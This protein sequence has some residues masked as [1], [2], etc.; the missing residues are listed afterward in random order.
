MSLALEP[1]ER[2]GKL[3]LWES[4]SALLRFI[5]SRTEHTWQDQRVITSEGDLPVS[6]LPS[7]KSSR[8]PPTRGEENLRPPA[9]AP[10][11]Q[12]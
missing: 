1:D 8:D 3:F 4:G 5:G 12:R 11:H 9:P 2:L 7:S 10:G 6:W